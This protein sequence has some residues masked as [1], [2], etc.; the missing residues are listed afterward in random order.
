MRIWRR[1][2]KRG[3]ILEKTGEPTATTLSGLPAVVLDLQGSEHP[4][5]PEIHSQITVVS[6]RNGNPYFITISSPVNDWESDRILLESILQS[7][8][9][10]E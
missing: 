8:T 6:A 7:V 5:R 2:V 4:A 9:I 10:T 1:A 3:T